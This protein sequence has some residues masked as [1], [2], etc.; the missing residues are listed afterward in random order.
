MKSAI[1]FGEKGSLA[2]VRALIADWW[3]VVLCS[4]DGHDLVPRF[5][6]DRIYLRCVSCSFET[7]GWHLKE[8]PSSSA[9]K[10]ALAG[11]E[12]RPLPL[13]SHAR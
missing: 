5:E 4:V 2:I 3:Q 6:P 12:C 9:Q 11:G 10:T 8:R 13:A 7:P 1:A